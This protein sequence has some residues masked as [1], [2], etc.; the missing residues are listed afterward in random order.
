MDLWRESNGKRL[1]IAVTTVP[2]EG[3]GWAMGVEFNGFL[4]VTE[5]LIVPLSAGTRVVSHFWENIELASRFYWVEDRDIRL[6]FELLSSCYREGSTADALV[7]VMQ[8]V[9]FDSRGEGEDEH[10]VEAA[11]ALAE[12]LTGVRLTPELL[13]GSNYTCGIVIVP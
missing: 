3:G 9:G 6:S 13:E 4:G 8:T 5:E 2:G 12:Y 7:D 10:P 11:F 1:L